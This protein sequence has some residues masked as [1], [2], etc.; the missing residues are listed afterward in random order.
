MP[1][2]MEYRETLAIL[3]KLRNQAEGLVEK[4]EMEEQFPSSL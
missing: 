4:V 3:E 2:A 1:E